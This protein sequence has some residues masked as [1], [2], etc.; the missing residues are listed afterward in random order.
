[1]IMKQFH[2]KSLITATI[3]L[4]VISASAQSHEASKSL[5]K[6]AGVP[7]NVTLEMS[8]QSADL[9]FFTTDDNVVK[10][11]TDIKISGKSKEDVDKV[12][13][14][15]EEFEFDLNGD[16][17][18]IDTR[19]YKSMHSVNNR[20]T[21]TLLNGDKVRINEFK[22]SHEL[23]IP[24][25]ANLNLNNKYSDIF[26]QSLDGEADLNLYSSKLE[27]GD[28]SK[29]TIIATKYSK[30]FVQ[31]FKKDIELD[32]YDS[33]LKFK[34]SGNVI[35]K[36]KYSK[37]EAEESGSIE[38]ESYDDKYYIDNISDL[39]LNAKYSDL[40][41]EAETNQLNLELYDCNIKL[42]SAKQCTFNGRYS[43]L[44][45]GNVASLKIDDSYDN[46][47][48]LSK[49]K[50][51]EI[52]KSKY[53]KY[54]MDENSGFKLDDSY[55]D[56]IIIDKVTSDFS[57]ISLNGKYGNLAV[58]VG[59]VPFQLDFNIKYAKIDIP[60]DVNTIKHVEKSSQLELLANKSG[61]KIQVEG[62]DMKVV[63]K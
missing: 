13:K 46:D 42:K 30:L 45:L 10:I 11:K 18:N 59:H 27:A 61:G 36:S 40:V 41:S 35:V 14:A 56:D 38:A 32:L 12:I 9:K 24:K 31:N 49:T 15:I 37:I 2:F 43:E 33:D 7:E 57:E 19:F 3:F 54:E 47:F 63:V 26:M 48:Q 60:E 1:M 21:I 8:N 22:I 55:D 28:F 53:S 5:N 29:N 50:K 17:L 20:R 23:H 25:T 44:E 62:Y 51:V 58:D 34:K 4:I 39:K 52:G 6:N 16:V